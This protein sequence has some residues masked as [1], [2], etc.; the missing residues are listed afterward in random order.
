MLF[1]C[2]AYLYAL[3]R[4]LLPLILLDENKIC[5]LYKHDNHHPNQDDACHYDQDNE[6]EHQEAVPA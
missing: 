4:H 2:F 3:P 5:K 1:I 6:R